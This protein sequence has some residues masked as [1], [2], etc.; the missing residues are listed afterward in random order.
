MAGK[1]TDEKGETHTCH[2]CQGSGYFGRVAAF[3]LLVINDDLRKMIASGSSLSQ[4]KAA[5]RKNKMLYLQEEALRKVI[6]GE[7]SIQE[8]IRVSQQQPKK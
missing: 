5:A 3:E 8:V 1:I 6:A 7:T 2:T 4:I